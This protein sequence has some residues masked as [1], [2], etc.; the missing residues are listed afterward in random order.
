[1]FEKKKKQFAN[2]VHSVIFYC[3]KHQ[4]V[5]KER[6]FILSS[7]HHDIQHVTSVGKR[8]I[9]VSPTSFWIFNLILS[10]N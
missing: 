10:Q 4:S 8:K 5:N 1:L 2:F 7:G 9:N 3:K 6:W